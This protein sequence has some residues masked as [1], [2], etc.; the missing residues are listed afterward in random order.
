MC[1]KS[2]TPI[3]VHEDQKWYKP[4]NIVEILF[5]LI[6]GKFTFVVDD[7]PDGTRPDILFTENETNFKDMYKVDHYTKY[8]RDGFHKYV[9]HGKLD[10]KI[11]IR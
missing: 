2:E 7:A 3:K 9:I 4:E 5:C 11:C 10:S 1:K 6:S 8:A